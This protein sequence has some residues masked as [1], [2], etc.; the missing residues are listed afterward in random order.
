MYSFPRTEVILL[1]CWIFR[2]F[3]FFISY[4]IKL[5][6]KYDKREEWFTH[7]TY[8]CPRFFFY[9]GYSFINFPCL[10]RRR[11]NSLKNNLKRNWTSST[12]KFPFLELGSK[13]FIN[14]RLTLLLVR[15][16]DKKKSEMLINRAPI[17]RGE[18]ESYILSKWFYLSQGRSFNEV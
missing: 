17:Q 2:F 14:N 6:H 3:F 8:H 4:F 13:L 15:G 10:A 7:L 9:R 16:N 18:C 12:V 1:L 11:K 5:L